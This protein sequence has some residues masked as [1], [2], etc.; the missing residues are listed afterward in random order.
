MSTNHPKQTPSLIHPDL[1]GLWSVARLGYEKAWYSRIAGTIVMSLFLYS[2]IG[3]FLVPLLVFILFIMEYYITTITISTIIIILYFIPISPQPW[4]CRLYMRYGSSYF[5]GGTSLCYECEPII[6]DPKLPICA[7]IHP[8]GLLCNSYFLNCGIRFRAIQDI[9][10]KKIRHEFAGRTSELQH[11]NKRWP[12]RGLIVGYLVNAPIFNFV[13]TK[14]TGC[15]AS[16]SNKNLKSM[17]RAGESYG[18]LPGGFN[19]ATLFRKGEN[20]I[21]IRKRK[22]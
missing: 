20:V 7:G 10:D 19:E 22:G 5:D 3:G 6:R 16:S 18:I 8:H 14:I 15:I 12:Y 21:Y 9:K 4:I 17:M 2:W 11:V 1:S 13:I